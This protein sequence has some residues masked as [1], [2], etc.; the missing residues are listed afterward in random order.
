MDKEK[1]IAK[2]YLWSRIA[3]D[4]SVIYTISLFSKMI[5]LEGLSRHLSGPGRMTLFKSIF[6]NPAFSLAFFS[7]IYVGY[8]SFC[9]HFL[10]GNTVGTFQKKLRFYPKTSPS[11]LPAALFYSIRSLF[12][13]LTLGAL[14]LFIKDRPYQIGCNKMA[15][16]I[17]IARVSLF[18]KDCPLHLSPVEEQYKE[19]A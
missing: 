6:F 5:F 17:N 16:S 18:K 12:N 13:L 14:G 11:S 7:V 10:E 8:Y 4:L 2:K 1:L 19:V 3:I 9:L 15:V